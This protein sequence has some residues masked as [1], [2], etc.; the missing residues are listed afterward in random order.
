MNEDAVANT[1]ST[2]PE[3]SSF[4]FVGDVAST[5]ETSSEKPVEEAPKD[6][7]ETPKKQSFGRR[8]KSFL[9]GKKAHEEKPVESPKAVPRTEHKEPAAV[10]EEPK[11]TKKEKSKKEAAE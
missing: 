8:L 2:Q 9:G 10:K 1:T 11:E 4:S 7:Q 6:K 3:S 5:E